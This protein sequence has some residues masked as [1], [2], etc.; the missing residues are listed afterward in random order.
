MGLS[1][2]LRVTGLGK[3]ISQGLPNLRIIRESLY[4]LCKVGKDI[5]NQPIVLDQVIIGMQ[6]LRQVIVQQSITR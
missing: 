1:R 2:M 4:Q 6:C 3:R 5:A